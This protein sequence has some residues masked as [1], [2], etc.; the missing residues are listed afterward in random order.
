[1][2]ILSPT[3][4][5]APAVV[6]SSTQARSGARPTTE[7]T[8][9]SSPRSVPILSNPAM[10]LDSKLNMVVL[11]FYDAKGEIR[12]KI[13]SDRELRAYQQG[14][15]PELPGAPAHIADQI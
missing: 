2:T 4:Q 13:P 14:Q 8:E 5:S 6:A 11:E 12:A 3:S 10:R 15:D 9:A 1:M 7:A